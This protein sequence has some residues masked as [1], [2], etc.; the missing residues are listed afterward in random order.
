MKRKVHAT[1][2]GRVYLELPSPCVDQFSIVE[3]IESFS[4]RATHDNNDEDGTGTYRGGGAARHIKSNVRKLESV[5][6]IATKMVPEL[7]EVT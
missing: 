2:I 5:Q 7:R 3:V 6:R 1:S 4:R